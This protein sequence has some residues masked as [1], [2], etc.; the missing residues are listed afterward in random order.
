MDNKIY[1]R[2]T[3][4]H[5]CFSVHNMEK[6]RSS[7]PFN[8]DVAAALISSTDTLLSTSPLTNDA[9]LDS[10]IKETDATALDSYVNIENVDS[11]ANSEEYSTPS[12]RLKTEA[13]LP[14]QGFTVEASQCSI[15]TWRSNVISRLWVW[16]IGLFYL[17]KG[18]GILSVSKL[19][20]C[21]MILFIRSS[22]KNIIW[23]F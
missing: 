20:D 9:L 3:P 10:Q 15:F 18:K 19:F 5:L 6:T 14:M 22:I 12:K 11:E 17:L 8:S 23:L 16:Q 7:G 13:W 2:F 4:L 21:N 1:N